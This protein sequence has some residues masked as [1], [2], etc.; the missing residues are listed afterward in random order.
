MQ[1]T[2]EM[3]VQSLGWEDPLEKEMATPSNILA[4]KKSH[5]QRNLVGYSP[6]SHKEL[7]MTEWA[8][9]THRKHQ[10]EIVRRAG[11]TLHNVHSWKDC[12]TLGMGL[13]SLW[14]TKWEKKHSRMGTIDKWN[15]QGTVVISVMEN[16]KGGRGEG[17]NFK[18][19]R[20]G[21]ASAK[22]CCWTKDMKE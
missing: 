20:E 13:S 6:W 17:G 2:Q 9:H 15:I 7:N 21:K 19:D 16:D 14:W 18:S 22:R 11:S 1:E 12:C 10:R 5:G 3:G 4:G 8:Q